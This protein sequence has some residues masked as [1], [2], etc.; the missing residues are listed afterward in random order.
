MKRGH[1]VPRAGAVLATV[2]RRLAGAAVVLLTV[3]LLVFLMLALAPGD[4]VSAA[5]GHHVSGEALER[6]RARL[7]LDEPLP[8][9]FARWLGRVLHADLGTSLGTGLPVARLIG[10]RLEPTLSLAGTTLALALLLGLPLGLRAASRPGGALDRALL[11]GSALVF[12]LPVF[13]TGM[14][15]VWT[16]SLHWQVLPAQGYGRL[17][18]GA[19]PWLRSLVLPTL[20]LAAVHAAL[21]ARV[22]RAAVAQAL[23]EPWIRT[24]RAKGL[25]EPRVVAWHALAAAGGPIATVVGHS[26]S[27]LV[28]GVVVTESVFALPGLG[29]LTVE[30]AVSRDWPL[31]QGIALVFAMACITLNL[32]VDLGIR[33]LDPRARP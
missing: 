20:A 1:D 25:G 8:L 24:A 2:L 26:A 21:I 13:V 33:L 15:L 16:F 6:M 19:A 32:L 5:V 12:A 3:A 27:M 30:A 29:S 7:G 28:G 31:M 17:A 10:Q 23:T 18:D 9:Q 4:A 22:T 11:A 14:L